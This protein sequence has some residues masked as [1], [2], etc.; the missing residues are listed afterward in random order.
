[1]NAPCS[2]QSLQQQARV[3]PPCD[4]LVRRVD[5][6]DL[7]LRCD[8]TTVTITKVDQLMTTGHSAAQ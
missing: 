5:S 7:A 1:M 6:G 2:A 8:L 4:T 3:H